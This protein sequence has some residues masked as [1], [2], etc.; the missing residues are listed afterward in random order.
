MLRVVMHEKNRCTML[1]MCG[2]V[3]ATGM[4]GRVPRALEQRFRVRIVIAHARA[5]L[6]RRNPKIFMQREQIFRGVN[7]LAIT[8]RRELASRNPLAATRR[9]D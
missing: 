2:A 4:Y 1:R 5:R 9:H 8:T 6:R 3:E 7:T